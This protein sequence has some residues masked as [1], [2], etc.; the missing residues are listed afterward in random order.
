MG[1]STGK[2]PRPTGKVGAVWQPTHTRIVKRTGKDR[3]LDHVDNTWLPEQ[4]RFFPLQSARSFLRDI[5][6]CGGSAV[7]LFSMFVLIAAVAPDANPDLALCRLPTLPPAQHY[8]RQ[9][10][11]S[12]LEQFVTLNAS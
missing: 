4:L 5:G 10:V 1:N 3:Q 6:L 11:R 2:R 12:P 8:P 9:P 7:L